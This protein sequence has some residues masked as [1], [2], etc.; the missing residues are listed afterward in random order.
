MLSCDLDPSLTTLTECVSKNEQLFA[1]HHDHRTKALELSKT[2]R[3]NS[4]DK[5]ARC[6]PL[7]KTAPT[8]D[9]ALM[10]WIIRHAA[11]FKG[12]GAQSPFY[13]AVAGPCC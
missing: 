1:A 7:N 5:Y 12:D 11:W 4:R 10:K 2:V 3:H 13:R 6:S 8:D 9:S